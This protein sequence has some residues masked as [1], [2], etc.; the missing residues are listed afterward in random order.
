[1]LVM[2]RTKGQ[3]I[4]IN[5]DIVLHVVSIRGNQVSIGIDAPDHVQIL[6]PEALKKYPKHRGNTQDEGKNVNKKQ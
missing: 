6:R 2:G 5:D 3:K 1:M 4:R